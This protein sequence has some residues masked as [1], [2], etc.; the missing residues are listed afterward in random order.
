M[1]GSP[2]AGEGTIG[3]AIA[4]L[5]GIYKV[6]YDQGTGKAAGE[7]LGMSLSNHHFKSLSHAPDVIG[8]IF[9]IMDQFCNT[10]HFLD[11]G[12]LIVFD[13]E[14]SQLVGSNPIAKVFAGL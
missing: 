12:R 7:L 2:Q 14:A 5:E 13:T 11:N 3:N 4:K 9:S 6:N 8:M 10:S 1:D